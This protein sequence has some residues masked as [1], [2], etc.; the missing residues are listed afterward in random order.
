MFEI[1]VSFAH[2][3]IA[4]HNQT[5]LFLRSLKR[6]ILFPFVKLFE[7]LWQGWP[8]FVQANNCDQEGT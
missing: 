5:S 1:Q 4:R 3:T 7:L 6:S 2:F 8:F